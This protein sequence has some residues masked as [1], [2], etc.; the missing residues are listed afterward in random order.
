MGIFITYY[1]PADVFY[2]FTVLQPGNEWQTQ[3]PE[4]VLTPDSMLS[5]ICLVLSSFHVFWER[6]GGQH[7][8][9][10]ILEGFFLSYSNCPG[11]NKYRN[12]EGIWSRQCIVFLICWCGWGT[13]DRQNDHLA[14]TEPPNCI[15]AAPE[16][17]QLP[18]GVV[19]MTRLLLVVNRSLATTRM[20]HFCTIETDKWKL[21]FA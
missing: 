1:V 4:P 19:Q 21:S 7:F 16:Q 2:A 3:D 10:E 12:T 6:S 15:F 5:Y 18:V 13:G 8:T 14:V 11:L 20:L 9:S 17:G